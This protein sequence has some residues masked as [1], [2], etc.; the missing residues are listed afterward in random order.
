MRLLT[1]LQHT[2]ARELAIF[3]ALPTDQKLREIWL[4]G[5]ETNG[6]VAQAMRDIEG[7]KDWR[8]EELKPWMSGVDKKLIG[9]GAV[10]FFILGAAPIVFFVLNNWDRIGGTQ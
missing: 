6:H 9:A 1:E 2:D 10:V 7:I 4:N 3:E 5:K 8:D